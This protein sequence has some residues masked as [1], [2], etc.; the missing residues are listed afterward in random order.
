V[1][2]DLHKYLRAKQESWQGTRVLPAVAPFLSLALRPVVLRTSTA[3]HLG[4][5]IGIVDSRF[6]FTSIRQFVSVIVAAV[7]RL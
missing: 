5:L 4:P 3:A 7:R 1:N 2:N 6:M